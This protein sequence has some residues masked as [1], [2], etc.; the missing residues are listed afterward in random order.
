MTIATDV[1]PMTGCDV[2]ACKPR[3]PDL[4]SGR[5]WPFAIMQLTT[6]TKADKT[7]LF[8]DKLSDSCLRI[9][10]KH[11]ACSIEKSGYLVRC[12][13][14]EQSSGISRDAEDPRSGAIFRSFVF[15]S[16]MLGV[17]SSVIRSACAVGRFQTLTLHTNMSRSF[18]NLLTDDPSPVMIQK[19]LLA[20]VSSS[21]G[22]SWCGI[23]D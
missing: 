18:A 11:N 6:T 16:S 14:V 1:V 13:P 21:V 7:G 17:C 19:S 8:I 15:F 4:H 10:S 20:S 5:K 2:L 23:P 9:A 22:P 3:G 12:K